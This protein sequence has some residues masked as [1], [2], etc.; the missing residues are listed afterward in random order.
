LAFCCRRRVACG[1]HAAALCRVRRSVPANDVAV[2]ALGELGDLIEALQ[3][4]RD[5]LIVLFICLI[6]AVAEV[7]NAAVVLPDARLV[8][9]AIV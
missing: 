3:V 1:D 7:D 6:L 2:L 9:E 8:A 5:A 4:V